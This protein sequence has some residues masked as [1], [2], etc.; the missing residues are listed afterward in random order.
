M[1]ELYD[2]VQEHEDRLG[3][4]EDAQSADED[5]L[6]DHEDRVGTLENDSGQLQFPL[7]QDTIDL[8]KELYPTGTVTLPAPGG[9]SVN[10]VTITDPRISAG[11]VIMLTVSAASGTQG[12][13]SYVASAGSAVVT[14]TS[15][16]EGSDVSY[17]LFS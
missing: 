15:S 10:S 16:T 4:V 1:S 11:S 14:S 13:L 9:M 5:T 3:G 7:S 8:I 17:V 6:S 2:Q 12:D